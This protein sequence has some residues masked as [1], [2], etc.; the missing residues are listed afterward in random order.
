MP[1]LSQAALEGREKPYCLAALLSETEALPSAAHFTH[2]AGSG[3]KKNSEVAA[4][5]Y[6]RDLSF[7]S[8]SRAGMETGGI[9]KVRQMIVFPTPSVFRP[10][11]LQDSGKAFHLTMSRKMLHTGHFTISR[12]LSDDLRKR[13]SPVYAVESYDWHL[14]HTTGCR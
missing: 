12:L 8:L 10:S 3:G 14:L 4:A 2:V 5:R 7:R 11:Q 6:L 9:G 13:H 1:E